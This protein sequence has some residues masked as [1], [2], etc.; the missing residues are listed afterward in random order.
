MAERFPVVVGPNATLALQLADAAR[1]DAQV[2]LESLKSAALVPV[3]VT[4]V[5]L[6]EVVP[7]FVRVTD[8]LPPTPP[9]GTNAQLRLDGA[10]VAPVVG[11]VPVPERAR[12]CGLLPA[13][14]VN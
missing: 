8:F 6:M 13:L 3:T 12:V 14:S 2:L 7:V 9:T 10:I 5:T 4:A 11:A 1:M